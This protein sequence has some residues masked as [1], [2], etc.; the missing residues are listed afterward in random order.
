MASSNNFL[1]LYGAVQ[2]NGLWTSNGI[3]RTDI[4][5]ENIAWISQSTV[6]LPNG[7]PRSA[8]IIWYVNPQGLTINNYWLGTN[9]S[10]IGIGDMLNYLTTLNTNNTFT[11]YF[12]WTG[13]DLYATISPIGQSVLINDALTHQR[14]YQPQTNTTNVYIQIK[15][16]LRYKILSFAGDQSFSGFYYYS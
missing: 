7:Q 4:N 16:L 6:T 10:L 15:N 5:P 9:P 8:F 14:T 13:I 3:V 1:S 12:N 11:E 2:V